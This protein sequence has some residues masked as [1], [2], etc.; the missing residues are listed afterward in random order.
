[1]IRKSGEKKKNLYPNFVDKRMAY[2][3]ENSTAIIIK[4]IFAGIVSSMVGIGGGMITNPILLGMGL[5]P[6]ETSST[7]TFLIMTTALASTFVYIFSG[8]LDVTFAICMAIPCTLS[9]YYGSLKILE[10]LNRTK[11][12]SIL[13]IIMFWFLVVSM[14]VIIFKSYYDLKGN[15]ELNLFELKNYC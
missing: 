7:S 9:A 14:A 2:L 13:L 8:Q 15:N 11:K 4:T 3:D 6:K 12:N 5:D 1:M 10:Y